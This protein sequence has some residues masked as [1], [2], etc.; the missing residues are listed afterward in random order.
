MSSDLSL[1]WT[2][3]SLK[4]SPIEQVLL[5]KAFHNNDFSFAPEHIAAVQDTIR[6]S[7]SSETVLY[8]KTGTGRIDGQDVNGWFIGYVEMPDRTCYF[9]TNIQ[10]NSH[11][12]GQKASEITASL[13]SKFH[14]Y[15]QDGQQ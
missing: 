2:D 12:T 3:A 11:I 14:I 6:I 8:G 7:S 15:P 4:I 13:L 9:A 5:L 10:G 1:Y